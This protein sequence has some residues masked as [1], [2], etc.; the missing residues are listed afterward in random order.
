MLGEEGDGMNANLQEHRDYG[1]VIGLL[2]GTCVGAGLMM[3][4]A[5]RSGSELRERVTRSARTLAATASEQQQQ[6][7]TKVSGVV[8]E[9]ARKGQDVRDEV[10]EAVAR[11]AHEV[12]RIATSAR[13]ERAANA[14]RSRR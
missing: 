14:A 3:W 5:P 4:L 1:F 2:A 9:L 7:S 12:E 10:A 8:D 13:S 11:G 6:I